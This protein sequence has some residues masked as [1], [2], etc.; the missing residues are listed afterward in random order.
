M[1]EQK[2]GKDETSQTLRESLVQV[3]EEALLIWLACVV[4]ESV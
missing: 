3:Q 1:S 4:A 2:A